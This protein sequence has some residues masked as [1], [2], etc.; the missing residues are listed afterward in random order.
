MPGWDAVTASVRGSS[1]VRSG[2]VNQDAV[3]AVRHHSLAVAAVAD[4]H[5]GP[6][7]V[8]S[9]R[10]SRMAVAAALRLAPQL[11]DGPRDERAVAAAATRF[12]AALVESWRSEVVVDAAGDPFTAEE[13]SRADGADLEADVLVA[14]G[15]TLLVA[16]ATADWVALIQLGDGDILV[17]GEDA[18]VRDPVPGDSRL[19]AGQTTSLCLPTAEQDVRVAIEPAG[20][21]E[22]VMLSSD[23]YG[24]AFAAED[25]RSQVGTDVLADVRRRGIDRVGRDLPDWLA[26]SAEAGGDDVSVALLHRTAPPGRGSAGTVPAAAAAAS[27]L[28][29]GGGGGGGRGQDP[30]AA[31]SESSPA[32]GRARVTAEP[33]PGRGRATAEPV[34]RPSRWPRWLA[35]AVA[36]LLIGFGVGWVGGTE[37]GSDD[38]SA[39]PN[40]PPSTSATTPPS[41]TTSAVALAPAPVRLRLAGDTV[42]EFTPQVGGPAPQRVEGSG[43]AP[44]LVKLSDGTQW[45]VVSGALRVRDRS[46]VRA[47]DT[48]DADIGGILFDGSTVWA[49]ASDGSTLYSIDI[50][51][52][53]AQPYTV[54]TTGAGGPVGQREADDRD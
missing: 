49:V 27:A 41:S 11:F 28:G 12:T 39:D 37:L 6:R 13:R 14:Y 5:G 44:T 54:V 21:V 9:D 19:V 50:S 24:N 46:G 4:G 35:G 34:S 3:D 38:G 16:V 48:D 53:L 40:S 32:P 8:R 36:V 30:A 25:W 17:V 23:G 51:T 43:V 45:E 47:V 15:A 20:G 1:H 29:G 2:L 52:R 10:G 26:D 31:A 7:Y 22:L 18:A 33:A 42:V